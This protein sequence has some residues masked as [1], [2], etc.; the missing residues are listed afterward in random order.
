MARAID[1]HGSNMVLHAPKG[2]EETVGDLHTYTNR[3]CSVSCWELS[4]EELAEVAHTG[5]IFLSVF[6]GRTQPPVFLGG[7]EDVRGLV[8]DYGGVWRRT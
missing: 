5:R 8:V 2:S 4:A 3:M 7:E 1:F 6:S